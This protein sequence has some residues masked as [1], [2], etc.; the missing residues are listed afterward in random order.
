VSCHQRLDLGLRVL[1]LRNER[2]HVGARGRLGVAIQE[3]VDETVVRSLK[4]FG[5]P[6]CR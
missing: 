5:L 3:R 4:S 6:S 1:D 2:L